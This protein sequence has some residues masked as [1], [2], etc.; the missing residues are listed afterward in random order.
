MKTTVEWGA[1]PQCSTNHN[2]LWGTFRF[3]GVDSNWSEY[4]KVAF[5]RIPAG[6]PREKLKLSLQTTTMLWELNF[7]LREHLNFSKNIRGY[8]NSLLNNI[9][10]KR[11][12][13][14][15]FY[16]LPSSIIF[17]P[18]IIPKP[19]FNPMI[20]FRWMFWAVWSINIS[21]I[22]NRTF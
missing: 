19:F 7:K 17:L 12:L 8:D 6:L 22:S 9:I 20:I 3:D 16:F 15:P 5:T 1:S 14:L 10:I 21:Q 2:F 13:R 11:G 4:R 18:S